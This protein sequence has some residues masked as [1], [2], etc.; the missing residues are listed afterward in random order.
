MMPDLAGG[1]NGFEPSGPNWPAHLNSGG[2]LALVWIA[3]AAE[4]IKVIENPSLLTTG[5]HRRGRDSG[6]VR[7]HG[8]V[9][10][11]GTFSHD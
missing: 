5:H 3:F 9:R 10:R 4:V 1:G 7:V 6:T 8:L 11:W 2:C